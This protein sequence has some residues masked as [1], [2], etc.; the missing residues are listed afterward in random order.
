MESWEESSRRR[1]QSLCKGLGEQMHLL[2][3]EYEEAKGWVEG[4]QLGEI[5]G[6]W[7]AGGFEAEDMLCLSFNITPKL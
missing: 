2:L 5:T 7:N 3:E 4:E 1:S 6:L